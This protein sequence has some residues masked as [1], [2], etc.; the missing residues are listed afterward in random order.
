MMMSRKLKL[1]LWAI[2]IFTLIASGLAIYISYNPNYYFF[3]DQS[4]RSTWVHPTA[5]V[6]LFCTFIIAEAFILA[7]VVAAPKPVQLWKRS[8]IGAIVLIPWVLYSTRFVIHMP[9][10]ILVHHLWAWIITI[11]A[12]TTGLLSAISHAI[13]TA[14]QKSNI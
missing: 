14:K 12:V 4:D 9:G 1:I 10:Y 6:L 2:G 8:I 13:S 3:Y 11:I 5:N 7:T